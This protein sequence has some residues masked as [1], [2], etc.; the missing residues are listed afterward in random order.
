MKTNYVLPTNDAI[1]TSFK[2]I[3][4]YLKVIGDHI[5]NDRNKISENWQKNES[6]KMKDLSDLNNNV[7]SALKQVL[8][9]MKN[10]LI[11]SFKK[12]RKI[13]FSTRNYENEVENLEKTIKNSGS[14]NFKSDL[15]EKI[16]SEL[17]KFLEIFSKPLDSRIFTLQKEF[18]NKIKEYEEQH[19]IQNFNSSSFPTRNDQ[20]NFQNNASSNTKLTNSR[21]ISVDR[22]TNLPFNTH[23]KFSLTNPTEPR[24]NKFNDSKKPFP[25]IKQKTVRGIEN[26]GNSCYFNSLMQCLFRTRLVKKIV[27]EQINNYDQSIQELRNLFSNLDSGEEIPVSPSENLRY[28]LGLNKKTQEDPYELL[29]FLI[30][31]L[32]KI[33]NVQFFYM[34]NLISRNIE[35]GRNKVKLCLGI[36]NRNSVPIVSIVLWKGR[37]FINFNA[38]V[39]KK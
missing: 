35:R 10:E 31:K 21:G 24:S 2:Q 18:K 33:E 36:F 29:H 14:L 39:P 20:T 32:M 23:Q 17:E 7:I 4:N 37:N 6:K 1:N 9:D 28:L 30:T 19:Q 27:S 15:F 8:T 11:K 16:L 3:E 38:F 13:T 34:S 25:I 5:K 12:S 26:V 22:Y